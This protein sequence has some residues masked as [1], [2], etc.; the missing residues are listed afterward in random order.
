MNELLL[1]QVLHSLGYLKAHDHEPLLDIQSLKSVRSHTRTHTHT[2]THTH[3]RAK[4]KLIIYG[5]CVCSDTQVTT[6]G[7]TRAAILLIVLTGTCTCVLG[8]MAETHTAVQ[9]WR[10]QNN[11]WKRR[12]PTLAS[13]LH[14]Q[15][16]LAG[17]QHLPILHTLQLMRM[18][19]IVT[20]L[21]YVTG[22]LSEVILH[23]H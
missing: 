14:V 17:S 21:M 3:T 16:C 20:L 19:D 1:C 4:C 15:P 5:I 22:T 9:E 13:F 2:H 12:Q 7:L 18:S 11:R 23:I 10:G 8:T 6:A